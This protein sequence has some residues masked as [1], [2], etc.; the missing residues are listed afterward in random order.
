MFDYLLILFDLYGIKETYQILK[1]N[2]PDFSVIQAAQMFE[3][4]FESFP[5]FVLQTVFLIRTTQNDDK[6]ALSN[7]DIGLLIFSSQK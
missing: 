6:N 4:A 1:S 3:S 7:S 5:Q 2:D